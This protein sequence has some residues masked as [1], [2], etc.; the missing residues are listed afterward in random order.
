MDGLVAGGADDERLPA[1][2]VSFSEGNDPNTSGIFRVSGGV[3]TELA[4]MTSPIVAGAV[5]PVRIERRGPSLR[6]FRAEE[7][8]AAVAD[9]ASAD[10]RVGFGSRNDGGTFDDLVVTVPASAP[11][12]EVSKGFF[13]RLWER[14]TSLFSG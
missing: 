8:V 6:V 3:R 10:G 2:F 9:A 12:A 1:H 7:Q 14:L 5:Y 4:D 13:A 11:P